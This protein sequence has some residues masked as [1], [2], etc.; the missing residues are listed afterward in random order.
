[1]ALGL[2]SLSADFATIAGYVRGHHERWDGSGYPAG[3]DIP[4]AR[5]SS[6]WSTPILP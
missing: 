3:V 2:A 5:G 1:V 4:W 6:R